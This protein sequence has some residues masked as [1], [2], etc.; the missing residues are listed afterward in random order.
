MAWREQTGAFGALGLNL[1]FEKHSP[2]G[3][4]SNE[5]ESCLRVLIASDRVLVSVCSSAKVTGTGHSSILH[6]LDWCSALRL[7]QTTQQGWQAEVTSG[8]F[9]TFSSTLFLRVCCVGFPFPV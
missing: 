5:M 6:P 8:L 9:S 1:S 7:R 4:G 2:A 3:D